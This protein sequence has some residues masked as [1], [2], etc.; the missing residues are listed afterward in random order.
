MRGVHMHVMKMQRSLHSRV[1][2]RMAIVGMSMKAVLIQQRTLDLGSTQQGITWSISKPDAM[3]GGV[4][5]SLN[6]GWLANG[7]C[8]SGKL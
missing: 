7:P 1:N 4:D 6:P 5:T 8:A 2:D 3:Q